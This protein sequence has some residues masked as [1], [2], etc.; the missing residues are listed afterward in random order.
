[1]DNNNTSMF[2][3]CVFSNLFLNFCVTLESQYDANIV[4]TF[5]CNFFL[6]KYGHCAGG[7]NPEFVMYI[8]C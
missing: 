3:Y 2:R 5:S 6:V 8:I 1:M 4:Q 7:M